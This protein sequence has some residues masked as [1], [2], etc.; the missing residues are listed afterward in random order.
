MI[1]SIFLL[2]LK[3]YKK[4]LSP[5]LGNHCRFYPTCSMYAYEAIEKHGIFK[6]IFL[7][8]RRLLKCHPWHPGGIDPVPEKNKVK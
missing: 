8:C 2:I 3:I 1:R 4:V 6:G 5:L 7:G